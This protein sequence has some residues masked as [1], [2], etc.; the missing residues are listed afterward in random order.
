MGLNIRLLI[1]IILAFGA[2]NFAQQNKMNMSFCGG[3]GV[4]S[5]R[6]NEI[7][8]EKNISALSFS[9]GL[10]I[11]Y[12]FSEKWALH[13]DFSFERKGAVAY[14]DQLD[15]NGNITGDITTFSNF[16]YLTMPLLLKFSVHKKVDIF[17]NA[18]GFVGYLLKQNFVIKESGSENKVADNLYK[19]KMLDFGLSIGLGFAIPIKP[20]LILNA[21]LRNNLGVYNV[22][23]VPVH[24]D[25]SIKTNNALLLCSLTYRLL[26]KK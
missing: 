3:I 4:R 23:K 26:Q 1:I 14:A 6:G 8:K 10:S 24:N 15:T 11:E 7:L 22:S 20:R 17:C 16:D 18:G 9:G 13:T 12:N 5:L 21:E 19:D 25:G 2:D